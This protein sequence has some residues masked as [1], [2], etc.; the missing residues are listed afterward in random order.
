M[1]HYNV[2]KDPPHHP[3]PHIYVNLDKFA[4][5]KRPTKSCATASTFANVNYPV[6]RD[7]WPSCA[8]AWLN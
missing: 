3:V 2:S 1:T 6:A 4:W 8:V 7:A 5:F